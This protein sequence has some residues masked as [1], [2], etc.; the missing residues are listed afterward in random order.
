[1]LLKKTI[2]RFNFGQFDVIIG[3]VIVDKMPCHI[4]LLNT[5]AASLLKWL[6]YPSLLCYDA[7]T[8]AK[9]LLIKIMS[10][11]ETNSGNDTISNKMLLI[12]SS[13]NRCIQFYMEL[14]RSL[15][16]LNDDTIL[17]WLENLSLAPID[18][19]YMCK[20]ILC[21]IFLHSDEILVVQKVCY[22]LVQIAREINSFAS[23]M[24]S[25]LL[26]KLTKTHD[27]PTLKYL[28][29][30][31]PE[32][33]MTKE[34]LP[35]VIHTLDTLL[36]SGKPLKYFAIQLYMKALEKE[37]RC[38]RFISTALMDTMEK[39]HSWHSDVTCARAIKYICESRPEH[40][41]ELVPL[42]S[43]ILNR[44]VDLNG[45][46]AS[47]LTLNSISALCKSAVIGT[48]H[49]IF[50]ATKLFLKRHIKDIALLAIFLYLV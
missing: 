5:L 30:T 42:L 11:K 41:E 29:L 34:N 12:F 23:H 2:A 47:A 8:M 38:Y 45:G 21:G 36:N 39:D 43:Q 17:S 3:T 16:S 18:L 14:I 48:L 7:L 24:L 44:C 40:G 32:F 6:A 15:Y 35:I 13:S 46:A 49:L 10:Q 28:L 50:L 33:A 9:E 37:P 31:V 4:T 25:L 20:L 26:H 1:M 19:R 22:I 27:S